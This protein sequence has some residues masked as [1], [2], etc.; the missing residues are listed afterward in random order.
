M[1]GH[2]GNSGDMTVC[3]P[4]GCGK[5]GGDDCATF[6]A[7]DY[8]EFSCCPDTIIASGRMCSSPSIGNA[9]CI[10]NRY[11]NCPGLHPWIGDGLCDSNPD[12][13]QY[14]L[15]NPECEYDGGDCC[16]CG[17]EENSAATCRHAANR[18]LDP[19]SNCYEQP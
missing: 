10:I 12:I 18:C 17:C 19:E 4:L 8:G 16:K 2:G 11:P 9:P 3:C 13:K 6:R 15:N 7:P 14:D 1:P 5:C